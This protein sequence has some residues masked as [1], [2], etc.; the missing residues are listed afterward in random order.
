P[1]DPV[2]VVA[3][4]DER[5]HH[6]GQPDS[7]AAAQERFFRTV[8][9][10]ERRP[11]RT[12]VE[13]AEVEDVADLDRRLEPELAAALRTAV[14][15][16][17]LPEVRESRLVVTT[18]LDAAQVPSVAVGAGHVLALA[19]RLVSEDLALE[20]DRAERPAAGAE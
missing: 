13:T 19:K 1:D 10:E 14:A 6:A 8:L 2:L 9:V 7:V 18:C 20:A 12:G 11:E 5:G 3:L 16:A 4:L 17:G 15:L